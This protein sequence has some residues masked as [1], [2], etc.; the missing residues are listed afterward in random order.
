M[1]LFWLVTY[2][3]LVAL[4]AVQAVLLALQTWEHRR[5]ARSRLRE[6][7][8]ARPSGKAMIFAPCRGADDDLEET[9]RR[10]FYQDYD[11]YEITFIVEDTADPAYDR[12]RRLIADHRHIV[13]HLVIA[14][15]AKQSG[16]KVHNL[17]VATRALRP[18]I[19]FLVFV[20]SDARPRREWLRGLLGRLGD[21]SK[22]NVGAVTGY[23]WLVPAQPTPAN[24][25]L[26]GVNCC[27]AAMFGPKSFY[28]VWGGSWAI[29]RTVFESIGLR[30]AWKGT[31][32]DDL[33]ASNVLRRRRLG[34]RFEPAAMVASPTDGSLRQ[35]FSF[36]RRQYLIGRFYAPW[37]WALGLASVA[38]P[39][40]AWW[41]SLGAAVWGL[42]AGGA[43]WLPAGVCAAFYVM[44]AARAWVRQD[45]IGLYCPDRRAELRVA[46]RLDIV[47]WPLV[48]LANALGMLASMLGR[49]ITWRGITYK[50]S[51]GGAIRIVHRDDAA[52]PED[53]SETY[54]RAA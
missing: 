27:I 20:D 14:G 23:R 12:I 49:H 47:A 9:L 50:L 11:D 8:H 36:L 25:L 6:L 16:Q 29:R 10:L 7:R 41:V 30:Q 52:A 4:A 32:S 40:L 19:E 39:N 37:A 24:H 18:D 22:R 21:R 13:C 44:N 33:V 26:Y 31:L 51:A 15:R 42:A 54:R 34:V 17:R 53:E 3:I 43:V 2:G 48:S 1:G 38:L 45:L 28:P 35:V 5:F 46:R